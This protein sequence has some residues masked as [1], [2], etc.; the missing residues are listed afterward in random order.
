MGA[1]ENV[2]KA[3]ADFKLTPSA[4]AIISYLQDCEGQPVTKS[5]IASEI[6][7]CEKTI[8]RLMSKM[9]ANGYIEAEERWND[10]GAQLANTYKV[11][12]ER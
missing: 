10:K 1:T 5:A 9:R 7:R 8:D 12:R 6:G 4:R 2:E 11:L 3:D